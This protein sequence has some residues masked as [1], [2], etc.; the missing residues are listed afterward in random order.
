MGPDL[1]SCKWFSVGSLTYFCVC[2]CYYNYD[3]CTF[4]EHY[5]INNTFNT[6]NK[7]GLFKLFIKCLCP[8]KH[9]T[10]G[11]ESALCS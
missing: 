6:L 9:L 4:L 1:T 2:Y 10:I 8:L 3:T 7:T 5:K 11:S